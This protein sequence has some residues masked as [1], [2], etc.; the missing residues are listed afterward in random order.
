VLTLGGL[1][2]L[3]IM[4][5]RESFPVRERLKGLPFWAVQIPIAAAVYAWVQTLG[6]EPLIKLDTSWLGWANLIAAPL[7]A[8]LFADFLFYWY[9][10]AQHRF[11]WRFHAPHHAFERLTAINSHH[12]WTEPLFTL[13]AIFPAALVGLPEGGFAWL[14]TAF[15]VQRYVIH[16]DLRFDTT[17]HPKL[18]VGSRYHRIHHSVE[19]R[20]R[21][22]NFGALT[23]MWDWMFGTLYWPDSKPS[24]GIREYR[25]PAFRDWLTVPFLRTPGDIDRP[26]RQVAGAGL[27]VDDAGSC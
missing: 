13:A 23:P 15:L 24:I 8:A 4:F 11:L 10:R 1:T 12:H 25:E 21:D 26:A 5:G 9:H 20:H 22:K 2:I 19:E 16:S 18:M 3:E 7:I 17:L 6:I 14:A 27:R